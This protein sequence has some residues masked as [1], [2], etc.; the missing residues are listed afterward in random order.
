[1]RAD[2]RALS[3][4]A[5]A[6]MTNVGLVKR[7]AREIENGQGPSLQEQDDGTLV[8]I[9]PDGIKATLPPGKSLKDSPC[10]CGATTV[11]RHRVAAVL[12]FAKNAAT[13]RKEPWEITEEELRGWLGHRL[14]KVDAAEAQGI[15]VDIVKNPPVARF[16]A[17]TVRF[18]AG[19]DLTH[20]ICDCG[21]AS[22]IHIALAVRAF[23][24]LSKEELQKETAHLRLGPPPAAISPDEALDQTE[25]LLVRYLVH[26]ITDA[27]GLA[28]AREEASA[29]LVDCP[30][31]NAVL[32]AI[33]EQRAAWEIRSALHDA[34]EV[35][36][37]LT[38]AFARIRASRRGFDLSASLGKGEPLE[39]HLG[40][41]RLLSLGARLSA[42]GQARSLEILFWDGGTV[43][44]WTVAIPEKVDPG[45]YIAI[46]QTPLAVL[47]AGQVVSSHLVRLAR[48]TIQIERGRDTTMMPQ[49]GEWSD[50]PRPF[51]FEGP[52][53]LLADDLAGPPLMLRP[54]TRT[55]ALRVIA[56]P[57]G[58]TNLAFSPG[59]QTLMGFLQD[60]EGFVRIERAHEWFAPGALASLAEALPRAQ[61][62]S[63][64]LRDIDGER[65][66][67]P[68]ALVTDRVIIPDLAPQAPIPPLPIFEPPAQTEISI[69]LSRLESAL[70]ALSEEGIFRAQLAP[71]APV[72]SAIG[73]RSIASMYERLVSARAAAVPEAAAEAWADLA[74]AVTLARS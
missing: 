38:E 27:R 63:G 13:T 20:A 16:A 40:R 34:S 57:G 5:L 37:L 71:L 35:R 42:V 11:C 6:A 45:T 1:M 2:L 36:R 69:V 65:V 67:E 23:G 33:E 28:Q 32:V 22:C 53:A 8:A 70:A 61:Y 73:L 46:G 3:P 43:V 30:W 52:S 24:R 48:R 49:R 58:V 62:I 17:C 68:I 55:C 15:S 54:R 26:G 56:T 21:V 44:S 59:R 14:G 12:V 10:T 47:A 39:N 9:F 64:W 18:L 60:G 7:A 74:I 25:R 29:R 66:L 41:T 72:L 31:L 50:V 19:A 51:G 4:E